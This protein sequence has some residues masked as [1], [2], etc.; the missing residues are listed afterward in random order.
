MGLYPK[1]YNHQPSNS[2]IS[3]RSAFRTNRDRSSLLSVIGFAAITF[4]FY[5]SII[6]SQRHPWNSIQTILTD[7]VSRPFNF[8]L[9]FPSS[10]PTSEHDFVLGFSASSIQTIVRRYTS[11]SHLAGT[12]GDEHTA[13]LTQATWEKLLGIKAQ[14][15]THVFDAGTRRARKMLYSKGS[16]PRVWTDRYYPLVTF[17]GNESLIVLRNATSN[18][19]IFTASL[20]ENAHQTDPTARNGSAQFPA[21]HGFSHPGK[22]SGSLVYVNYGRLEDFER[23]Q[24]N[25]I[26]VKDRIV[27]VRYGEIYRGLK[28]S[29]AEQFGAKGVIIYTDL[30]EDGASMAGQVTYPDGPAREQSSIQRGSVENL[31][32]QPGDP[33][34]PFIPAYKHA[35]R[36]EPKSIPG[37]PSLPISWNDAQPLLKSLEGFGKCLG[38]DWNGFGPFEYFTGPSNDTNV[39]IVNDVTNEVATIWNTYA[40]IPGHIT[41]EVVV[42]GNHRDAWIFGAGDPNSGTAVITEILKSFGNLMKI[43]W[44]PRRSILFASWDGEELGLIGSTEFVEDHQKWIKRNVA[45]YLNTDISAAG[46]QL[47]IGASPSLVPV[48]LDV[49]KKI[50]DPEDDQ[51][52][53]YDRLASQQNST[54]EISIGPLGSGSDFTPFLQHVGIASADAGFGPADGDPV[55][56]YHSIYDSTYWMEK[57]GD[58]GYKRHLAVARLLGL[59][60]LRFAESKVLPIDLKAYGKALKGYINHLPTSKE[61]DFT[62]LRKAVDNL[63]L[64]IEHV[65]PKKIRRYNKL[66]K[67]FE[68]GFIDLVGLRGR[69][70]YRNLIIAPGI[71]LGYGATPLPGL[72]E[73]I[74]IYKNSSLATIEL[75]RVVKVIDNN[76]KKV[77]GLNQKIYCLKKHRHAN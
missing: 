38:H 1:T 5:Q 64:A 56:H 71:N 47:D 32:M 2:D 19:T 7:L 23:L 3:T 26:S 35:K 54:N 25:G 41:D 8:G 39:Q 76:R 36:V 6:P 73:A 4:V 11:R 12:S 13:S 49:S 62:S 65:K 58:P 28:V 52:T 24:A 66:L 51:R 9:I 10:A 46:S 20:F 57:F 34:T 14:G 50:E 60:T 21:F 68:S 63:C 27:L 74:K 67:S 61:V 18:T 48:F 30:A 33:L 55:Y 77:N 29:F 44:R 31:S 72:N 40:L 22:A 69:A 45:V 37:I 75:N 17:P 53:L 70:W 16:K 43:G 15:D 42:I 59:V